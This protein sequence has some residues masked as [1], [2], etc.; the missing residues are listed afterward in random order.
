MNADS[1]VD[2]AAADVRS[3]PV[4]GGDLALYELQKPMVEPLLR[5]FRL[6]N[7]ALDVLFYD[8]G[9]FPSAMSTRG[10][11]VDTRMGRNSGAGRNPL[12]NHFDLSA[13]RNPE[14]SLFVCAGIR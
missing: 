7:T 13:L 2:S 5:M 1:D 14:G 10:M 8:V 6:A 3:N 9:A 11:A 12:L 4:A